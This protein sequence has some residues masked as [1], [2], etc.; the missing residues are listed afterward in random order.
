[1]NVEVKTQERPSR[2]AQLAA[3]GSVIVAFLAS[4]HHLIHMLILLVTFGT[5]GMS[6][7]SAFPLLRRG[8]MLMSLVMMGITFWQVW[9][10]RQNRSMVVLGG[11][12]V[13]LTLGLLLWSIAQFRL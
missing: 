10:W 11:I 1:M 8:M 9:H 6:F 3:I 12:S 2:K 4:Q 7:M 13:A 5:A